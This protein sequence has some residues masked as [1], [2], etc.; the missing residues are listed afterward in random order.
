MDEAGAGPG[1]ESSEEHASVRC[2]TCVCGSACAS[3]VRVHGRGPLLCA[4]G[5]ASWGREPVSAC[6]SVHVCTREPV[7]VF[8]CVNQWS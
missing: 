1:Q 3:V 4:R 5:T 8:A 7:C 6:A 2:D